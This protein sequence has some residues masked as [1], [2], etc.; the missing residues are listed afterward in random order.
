MPGL[1][2]G[3]GADPAPGDCQQAAAGEHSG[4]QGR[5]HH[6]HRALGRGEAGPAR[7]TGQRGAAAHLR[8][9]GERLRRG[10]VPAGHGEG[11]RPDLVHP[12][13][14][15]APHRG[16]KGPHRRGAGAP[17]SAGGKKPDKFVFWQ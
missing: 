14:S 8:G 17:G 16:A 13:L 5:P 7:H 2:P 15:G 4:R 6:R 3:P 9:G 10:P 11:L 12:P 1:R